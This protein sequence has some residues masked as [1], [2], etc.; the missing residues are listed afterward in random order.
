M[1][2]STGACFLPNPDTLTLHNVRRLGGGPTRLLFAHGF[3]CDQTIWR[4]VAPLLARDHEVILFDHVGAGDATA[5]YDARRHGRL[6]GYAEDVLGICQ[7]LGPEQL[8]YVG[9]SVSASIG[10]LA[11]A[12]APAHFAKLV[13]LNPSPRYIDDGDYVGGFS[14]EDIEAL[15]G[16]LQADQD[17][18]AAAM[19]PA[20]AGNPDRPELAEE[21]A[22]RFC[23]MDPAV[24]VGFARTT[25]T[26]DNRADLA[27]VPTRTLVLQCRDDSIAPPSVG[28]FVSAQLPD[29]VLV[30]LEVSGHCPHLS[31]PEETVAAIRS[32]L[33][34]P[35]Q[36]CLI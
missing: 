19:A 22:G 25:F 4:L 36:P 8:V 9:H 18:W 11:A 29:A 5:P 24:A 20:V 17:G 23:R 21:M 30:T 6:D 12:K 34:D 1:A 14:A 10:V 35:G 2:V 16:L 32:F 15:L 33:A 7:A 13:L 26:S 28:A 31:A 3:G 27:R